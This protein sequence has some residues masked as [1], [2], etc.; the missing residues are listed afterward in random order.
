[1][2]IVVDVMGGDHGC[3]VVIEGVKIALHACNKISGLCLVGD[4]AQIRAAMTEAR[5]QDDRV[6]IVHTTEVLTMEDKPLDVL[7]KKKD[8]SMA[9][10]LELVKQGQGDAMISRG[11][12]GGLVAAATVKLRPLENVERPAIATVLPTPQ[13]YFL[14]LDAGANS[15]CRPL[16]LAQFA[17]MG[18]VYSREILGNANPRVGI[19]SNGKEEMKGNDLTRE[20]AELCRQLDLNFLGYV[21]GHDLFEDHVDV[22]VSDGFIGNIVLK[23]CE[24]MGKAI[25]VMLETELTR[26]PLRKFGAALAYGGLRSIKRRMN[27][28]NYGGAPLLGLNGTVIKAHGSARA[29]AIKNAIRVGTE[30]IQHS[31]NRLITQEIARAKERLA[32]VKAAV[33]TA[34]A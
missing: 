28:D 29:L 7:R 30:T 12:T 11:N 23:T 18:S 22:V 31:I 13:K 14:L 32:T 15:E 26:N 24:S 9:R 6:E 27:A 34:A 33:Q 20:A 8:C 3:E 25:R 19:L 2:R 5:L 17:I 16:H 10:A 21:E 1:M 4:E